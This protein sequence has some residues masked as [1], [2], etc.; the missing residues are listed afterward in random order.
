MDTQIEEIKKRIDIVEFI[1]SF[2]QIKKT[3]RNFKACCP[4]HNEKT[5]S[6]VISPDRQIWHCF[7]TCGEGGDI[8]KF[9][10]K[11][12]NITFFEA[13]KELADKAGVKLENGQYEDKEW[14]QKDRIFKIN[15]LAS[16][17]Y[18]YILHQTPFGQKGLDYL[19]ERGMNPKLV[20]TFEL[21]YAPSSW[22]SLLKFLRKKG[23]KDYDIF[24]T[25]LLV[26]SEKGSYYDRFRGRLLFPIKD[27]KGN[28]VGFSGRLLDP[29][30]KTAK[31]V[32]TPETP[33]YHK[34][35]SLYGI[36][37]AKEAIRKEAN[38][39]LV[40]G[41]FDMIMPYQFGFEHFVA[42]KG[43]AVTKDQLAILKR[44]TPRITLALDTDEAGEEAIKRG[45]AEAE[46]L[47]LEIQIVRF[48]NAKDPDEAV[49]KDFIA[50]KKALANPMPIY[51][52][53][54]NS[55]RNKYPEQT[56]FH[57]KKIGEEMVPYIS[58]IKNPI[59]Q[60]HYI[61]VLSHVLEV[62]EE[63]IQTM[64]KKQHYFKQNQQR[65]YVKHE[66]E[67]IPGEELMQKYIISC[68]LQSENPYMVA[69]TIFAVLKPESFTL[70]ALQKIA[71]AFVDYRQTHQQQFSI[72]SFFQ[73]LPPELR[74]TADEL[75]LYASN[76]YGFEEL[77]FEKI[78]LKIQ[79]YSLLEKIKSL[80]KIEQT[81][82]TDKEM[83]EA[84]RLL[85][86]VEKKLQSIK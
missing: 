12:E 11:W 35:E 40:E 25:G 84:S 54:I 39:I 7:G 16:E 13:L 71:Q 24:E 55:A 41:E 6:F 73:S 15:Y 9:L 53:L 69:D 59:V 51:D 4:F 79:K 34:R 29:N 44:Y 28:I 33:V 10:M 72:Q 8:I 56:P 42:I 77:N 45:I 36:H 49:R 37:L 3:G 86:I 23:F 67:Q 32:N 17:F 61:K 22:D 70:P 62:S 64:L 47:E 43:A 19:K 83:T 80:S 14:S 58:N 31:Y 66:T 68:I 27:I 38:A 76:E 52:F 21:G 18:Q 5:P 57:K 1:G 63:S 65:R 48:E 82:E 2:V 75:Y 60:S 20:K 74:A 30:D 78:A 85:T 26:Q 50:F 46:K 81:S